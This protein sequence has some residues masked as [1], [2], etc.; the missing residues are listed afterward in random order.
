[1]I[2][3]SYTKKH[4]VVGILI[5]KSSSIVPII[6][7]MLCVC[8]CVCVHVHAFL[9]SNMRCMVVCDWIDYF[10][11]IQKCMCSRMMKTAR[12]KLYARHTRSQF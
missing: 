9:C 12:R 10:L 11:I 5:V 8:V 7:C 4:I 6:L 2:C 1:M 3:F